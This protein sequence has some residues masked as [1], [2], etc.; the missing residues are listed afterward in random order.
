MSAPRRCIW[1]RPRPPPPRRCSAHRWRGSLK[2]GGRGEDT[3]LMPTPIPA[4]DAQLLQLAQRGAQAWTDNVLRDF[5][6]RWRTEQAAEALLS[7]VPAEQ[8]DV[9]ADRLTRFVERGHHPLLTVVAP[10]P[11]AVA[12]HAAPELAA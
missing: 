5:D 3:G 11:R 6:N 10:H 9:M 1:T 4:T 2:R 7:D 12:N 8:R